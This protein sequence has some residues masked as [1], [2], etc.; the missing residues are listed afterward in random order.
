[1][2][3]Q[4]IDDI[5]KYYLLS[6]K[7]AGEDGNDLLHHVLIS[8]KNKRN[9]KGDDLHY[10]F[11]TILRN[12]YYNKNSSFNK[13][14]SRHELTTEIEYFEA[15][16]DTDQLNDILNRITNKKAVE[17]F[18]KCYLTSNIKQVAKELN[19][20]KMTLYRNYLIFVKNE[21]RKQYVRT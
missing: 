8:F 6:N 19:V 13:L 10:Y 16:Y 9:L 5:D 11:I 4:L 14:H 18:K 12:E 2:D 17:V 15:T 3:Q 1:M 7:I 20:S 21:I